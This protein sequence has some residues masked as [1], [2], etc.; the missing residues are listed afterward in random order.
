[1]RLRT[2]KVLLWLLNGVIALGI[3]GA[4]GLFLVKPPIP[5]TVPLDDDLAELRE[6]V[7][8]RRRVEGPEKQSPNDFRACW[9]ANL[10]A[11]A[12]PPP[13]VAGGQDDTGTKPKGPR[14]DT[15]LSLEMICPVPEETGHAAVLRYKQP[16]KDT[17]KNENIA[18]QDTRLV[19]INQKIPGIEPVAIIKA[20]DPFGKLGTPPSVD[21]S[22]SGAVVSLQLERELVDLSVAPDGSGAKPS[23]RTAFAGPAGQKKPSSRSSG[24]ATFDGN[25]Q[26]GYETRPGSGMWMIPETEADRL[27]NE[28]NDILEQ[29]QFST[30]T[31]KQGRPAGIRLDHVD[32]GSLILERGFQTNDV[33]QKVN[34][35]PVNSKTELVDWVKRNHER[36]SMFRVEVLRRGQVK[37]LNFRVQKSRN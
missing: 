27:G 4:L 3:L 34:G 1:M 30:Y 36:F 6:D 37:R 10:L 32:A 20:V 22:Y 35:Q 12:P 2:M 16:K 18:A 14:L 5:S 23:T 7:A 26:E 9:E 21:V 11:I 25:K 13:P 17:D 15:L 19:R 33:V 24:P 8:S 29:A 28:A 31:D